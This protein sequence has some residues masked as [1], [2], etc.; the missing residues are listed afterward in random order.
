MNMRDMTEGEAFYFYDCRECP[1]CGEGA[2]FDLGPRGGASV[3]IRM[4]CCG[5]E[6]NVIDPELW[7]KYPGLRIGQV[8]KEPPGYPPRPFPPSEEQVVPMSEWSRAV[9]KAMAHFWKKLAE[10]RARE[11][12]S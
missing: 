6:M 1:F 7:D 4:V 2:A 9:K 8:L 10:R 11:R 3:N 12:S 5:A